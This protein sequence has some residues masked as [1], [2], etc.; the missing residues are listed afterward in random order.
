MAS[1]HPPPVPRRRRR[2]QFRPRFTLLILYV[3][4]LYFVYSLA[5]A[6]PTLLEHLAALPPDADPQDPIYVDRAAAAT[7]AVLK[8]KP[9]GLFLAAVATVLLGAWR[10]W[11]PGLREAP[12][13]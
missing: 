13:D 4:A 1:P 8:G 12:P 7:R 10:G 2:T 3:A 9:F 11:L 6:A 5:L